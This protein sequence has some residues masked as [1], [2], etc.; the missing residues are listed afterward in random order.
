[1]PAIPDEV[2]NYYLTKSGF[3]CS[4]EKIRRL[5]SLA[6]QKFVSDI[7]EDALQYSKIRHHPHRDKRG[8]EGQRLVLSMD[9]LSQALREYG[10]TV[11]KPEYFVDR[12]TQSTTPLP[13]SPAPALQG[14]DKKK[15]RT[16]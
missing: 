8:K 6:A 7:A 5:V 13:A 11:K 2:V 16:K 14:P 3:V 12:G 4:D 9:D 10:I 15:K 1:V